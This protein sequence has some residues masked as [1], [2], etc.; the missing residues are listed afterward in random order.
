MSP[1][2]NVHDS[3]AMRRIP[4]VRDMM[5]R[6]FAT[7]RPDASV[8]EAARTLV[9]RRLRGAA[10]VGADGRFVGFVSLRGVLA[11]LAEFLHDERPA[12]PISGYLDPDPPRLREDAS[13]LAAVQ[14]FFEAGNADLALPVVREEALI[15][16]VTRLDVVRAVLRYLG[17]NEGA[18]PATLY[19]SALRRPDEGPQS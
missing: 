19:L 9:R 7:L 5:A 17:G 4:T 12:G 8:G 16:V 13:L 11:A 2:S 15:G 10:V 18:G 3:Q 14:I 6:D 1:R